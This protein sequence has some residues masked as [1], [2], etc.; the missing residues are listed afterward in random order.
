MKEHRTIRADVLKNISKA[1]LGNAALSLSIIEIIKTAGEQRKIGDNFFLNH[2][3]TPVWKAAGGAPNNVHVGTLGTAV[4]AALAERMNNTDN[5]TTCIITD[6]DHNNGHTWEAIMLA[7]KHNL[8]N[9]TVIIN[10]THHQ[11]D[12]FTENV[13]PLEPLT[14]KYHAFNWHT[15]EI[16]GHKPAHITHALREARAHDGPTAIIAHTTP[17]KGV[18]FMEHDTTWQNKPPTP[19]ELQDALDELRTS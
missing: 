12:G 18:R 17:G 6:A 11:A 19:P 7:S 16:D 3:F 5:H 13:L 10:R 8:R 2:H 15:I 9:L 14:S 4:G 1:G